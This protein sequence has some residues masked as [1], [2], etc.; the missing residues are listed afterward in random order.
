MK[1][2]DVKKF[3]AYKTVLD[4]PSYMVLEDPKTFHT[5]VVYRKNS[6]RTGLNRYY[7][8]AEAVLPGLKDDPDV[9]IPAGMLRELV[10]RRNARGGANPAPRVRLNAPRPWQAPIAQRVQQALADE[11]QM[12]AG[13]QRVM[14]AAQPLDIADLIGPDVQ[15][16]AVQEDVDF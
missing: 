9:M 11:A 16:A 15:P 3:E 7:Q 14:Y 8:V 2:I 12:N 6:P 4:L 5:V 10:V 13:Q 1:Q